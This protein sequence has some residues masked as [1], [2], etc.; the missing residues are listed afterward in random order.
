MD[1]KYPGEGPKHGQYHPWYAY[2]ASKMAN[3]LFTQ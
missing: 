1:G 3:V 2:A